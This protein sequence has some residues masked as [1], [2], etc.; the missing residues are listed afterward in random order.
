MQDPVIQFARDGEVGIAVFN[1]PQRLNPLSIEFQAR[2]RQILAEVAA[3]RSI[4]ALVLTGE[5]QGFCVGADLAGLTADDT[6]PRSMGE[7]VA[8]M[9]DDYTNPLIT[10]LQALPVPVVSAVNGAA[11]GAGVGL[12]LAADITLVA[13]AAYFY[14]PFIPKLGIVP[15]MGSS[16]FL[17]SRIGHA[18][19]MGLSLLGDRLSGEQAAQWGLVWECLAPERLR[20]EALTL[21]RR[22]A[23]L[24]AHG[25]IEARRAY[26]SA[27]SSTLAQ[28]LRYERDRQMEL[29]DRPEFAEGV[30]AFQE[31][32]E[33]KFQAR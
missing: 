21:A 28:Q 30:R 25:V 24:P 17:L 11:A 33:P 2:L 31:R 12:A 20:D 22:L 16:S 1:R 15:D 19:A 13:R 10:D 23:R 32:R 7:R 3:D 4:R 27:A 6:D 29:I 5:G 8:A 14:L 26:S 9:M 18:R